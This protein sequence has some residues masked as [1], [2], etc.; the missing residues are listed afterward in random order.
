MKTSISDIY[1]KTAELLCYDYGISSQ[2]VNELLGDFKVMKALEVLGERL[3]K[4]DKL[5]YLL[6]CKEHEC[7]STK[8]ESVIKLREKIISQWENTDLDVA[9]NK[10]GKTQG[11]SVSHRAKKLARLK[12]TCGKS[13]AMMFMEYSGI[14]L[15]FA[16]IHERNEKKPDVEDVPP[17]F[18]LPDLVNYQLKLKND[19]MKVLKEEGDEAK[20]IISLPTGAGKTR[21]AV[22]SYIEYLCPRFAEGK[23]LI[24]I[25]Q[26]E[27]LCEQAIK[28][29]QDLWKSREFTE[30]L[31]LYRLFGYHNLKIEDMKGGVVVCSINKLYN[32]IKN[33]E[34]GDEYH[35]LIKNCGACII[36][37]AHRAITMMYE[38][39]Y[40]YS[41]K[42]RGEQMFPICGLTA[43]PGRN[44][45]PIPLSKHFRYRLFTPDVP[46]QYKDKPILYFRKEKYLALP[47]HVE[48]ATGQ[49]FEFSE[50]DGEKIE[51]EWKKVGAGEKTCLE[52]RLLLQES[53]G[54]GCKN[55]AK[56]VQR[57]KIIL[58]KLLEL[59]EDSR[60]LVYACTVEHA[61]VLNNLLI[62][63]G[64]RSV[65]I[66]GD[67]PRYKRQSFIE[68]FKQN[69][70]Q[71]IVNHSVLT[72]G[73]DAPKTDTIVLCR[74]TFSDILYEQIVGRGLRGTKFGG[75]ETCTIIDFCDNCGRFGDQQSY[76]RFES[77]WYNGEKI[78]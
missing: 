28:T 49:A 62:A 19:L 36:D 1:R 69:D 64:K 44:D 71:F 56:N 75:T 34:E 52:F 55:L 76:K 9:F 14:N 54:E 78:E 73:F 59:P 3:E 74:P 27:E 10:Y 8:H 30:Y 72:T 29:F 42:L 67:T 11:R 60:V 40:E 18:K 66:T 37:E 47:Y 31:R 33:S 45:D 5:A 46:Q 53:I 22:E 57:N 6:R 63:K 51:A 41:K 65:V 2:L 38:T 48:I 58:N 25:A 16:G 50:K 24:W 35:Y 15:Y 23:Y 26:S 43:T 17:F 20:C 12:W 7:F 32:S 13:W 68:Q 39:F 21:V 77:F 61:E 4:V 70:I